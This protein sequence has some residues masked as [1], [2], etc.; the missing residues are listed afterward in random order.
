MGT[1]AQV[2]V[3]GGPPHLLQLAQDRI[4]DLERRWSRFVDGSEISTLNRYAGA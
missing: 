1:D 2:I 4:A 3:V